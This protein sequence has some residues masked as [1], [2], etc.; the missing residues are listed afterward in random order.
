MSSCF[1]PNSMTLRSNAHSY[2]PHAGLI[3]GKN[4]VQIL[5]LDSLIGA[6]AD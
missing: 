2:T 4:C 6:E 3:N 1:A 5:G